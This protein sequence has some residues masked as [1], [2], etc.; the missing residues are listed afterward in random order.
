MNQ[1]TFVRHTATPNT[2]ARREAYIKAQGPMSGRGES[3]A[4]SPNAR[5][6]KAGRIA[7]GQSNV[8]RTIKTAAQSG[9]NRGNRSKG[10]RMTNEAGRVATAANAERPVA[11]RE[12]SDGSMGIGRYTENTANA[13]AFTAN[14]PGSNINLVEYPIP[15]QQPVLSSRNNEASIP[16]LSKLPV[17]LGAS[18]DRNEILAFGEH[19]S[20]DES[21][22]LLDE[23]SRDRNEHF[24][25]SLHLEGLAQAPTY[26]GQESSLTGRQRNSVKRGTEVVKS[27][28]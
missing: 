20:I 21:V 7:T 6:S 17:S 23:R 14:N 8:R 16:V 28:R 9:N 19:K 26:A 15:P 10:S 5:K 25:R 24:D 18:P 13:G 11:S 4:G 3:R 22:G 12:L 27:R 2:L 1:T